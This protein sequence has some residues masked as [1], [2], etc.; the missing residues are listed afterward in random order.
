MQAPIHLKMR[1]R[2]STLILLLTIGLLLGAAA[3][4]PQP[5][6]VVQKVQG[7]LQMRRKGT[8][9]FTIIKPRQKLNAGDVVRTGLKSSALIRMSNGHCLQLS[10]KT[11]VEVLPPVT[12]DAATARLFGLSVRR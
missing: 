5:V 3:A 9:H 12:L 10:A 2:L 1:C 7:T 8:R 4:A 6:A 11:T